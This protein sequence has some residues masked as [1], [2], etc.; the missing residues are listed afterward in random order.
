[1]KMYELVDS[2]CFKQKKH[3]I[4]LKFEQDDDDDDDDDD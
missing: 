4:T 2:V 3:A 1:M